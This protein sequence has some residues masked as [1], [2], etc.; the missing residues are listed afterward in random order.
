MLFCSVYR[1]QLTLLAIVG[2]KDFSCYTT[3]YYNDYY[4]APYAVPILIML[5]S[6]Y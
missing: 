4:K 1:P 5:S 3:L 6:V 2:S